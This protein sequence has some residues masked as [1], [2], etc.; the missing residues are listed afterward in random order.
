[1]IEDEKILI[2]D[3]D[4]CTGCCLCELVCSQTKQGEYN[5]HKSYIRII[6]NKEMDVNIATL[7]V[8]CDFC[9]KCVESC[10]PKAISL[11]NLEKAAMFRRANK[12]GIFP[13]PLIGEK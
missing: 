1:M 10:L 11:V 6:K 3:G 13:A 8:R 5:P 9:N 12:I 7:D 2:F 4:K